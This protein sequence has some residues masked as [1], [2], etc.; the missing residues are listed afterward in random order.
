M[1]RDRS[2]AGSDAGPPDLNKPVHEQS[3]E[4]SGDDDATGSEGSGRDIGVGKEPSKRRSA[5]TRDS[6]GR[7][8]D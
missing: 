3:G 1:K 2:A 6:K 8:P 7:K 4:A 5:S